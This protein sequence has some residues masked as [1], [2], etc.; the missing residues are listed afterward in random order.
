MKSQKMWDFARI[1]SAQPTLI[2]SPTSE[3]E[4][5]KI[6]KSHP[7]HKIC[8]SGGQY[9]HGGQTL[10]DNCVSLNL[11]NFNNITNFDFKKK[12]ITT[13]SGATWRKLIEYLDPLNLSISEM[14]SYCNFTVGGSIGVNCHG[15]GM[16]YG[17][18][19]DSIVKMKLLTMSGQIIVASRCQSQTRDLFRAVIGGY[20]G[21]AIIL[22]ATFLVTDNY[23]I[24]RQI[25]TCK[26]VDL[27]KFYK[28]LVNHPQLVFY[29]GNIY[30]TNEDTI[31]N[32]CWFRSK[33]PLTIPDRLQKNNTTHVTSMISEQALRQSWLVKFMRARLEP[34]WLKNPLVV[35]RNYELTYDVNSLQPLTKVATTTI[36]Q[37]YFVPINSIN[38]F[39]DYFWNIMNMYM[40]NLLNVSLRYVMGTK[41]SILNYA[42]NDRIAVVLYI[43]IGNNQWCLDYAKD[44]SQ[45]L[46]QKAIDLSGSYYLPYLP[47]ATKHQ[48]K[49]AYKGYEKYLEIKNKYDPL[50]RLSSQFLEKYIYL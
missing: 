43:N 14:Q 40:V 49:T 48:F 11:K 34:Y 24:E 18:I 22:E 50:N 28:S 8:L 1:H 21:I 32:I 15:R 30:P 44:W 19:A 3:D 47:F 9:S 7:L 38:K 5:V 13:Q 29:N 31:V 17:T 41:I 16:L 42:P 45:K 36:L 2:F 33:K 25:L 35:W 26:S 46:I 23:P 10:L 20:G 12:L 4:I 39:L 6:V 27:I 37:E